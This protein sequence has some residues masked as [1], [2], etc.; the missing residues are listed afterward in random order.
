M[1]V[2][3]PTKRRDAGTSF[4]KLVAYISIR[5]ADKKLDETLSPDMPFSRPSRSDEVI[6]DR[7]VDYIKR[8]ALPD[9]EHII[10]TFPDGR[11]QVYFDNVACETNCFSIDTAAAEM[12]MVA[13]ENVRKKDPVYH[14][15]LSW[16]EEDKPEDSDIFSA[17]RH[18]LHQIGMG[19]HQFVTAIHRDTDN[20]H[21]HVAVNR[22]NPVSFRMADKY[23]AL[24][25]MQQCCRR[26]ERQ[27]GWT[28][29]NGSW[30]MDSNQQIVRVKRPYLSAPQGAK[31]LE[32]HS[33]QESL[34]SYA[35][36]H[37]RDAVDAVILGPKPSWEK[38]HTVL[39]RAGLELRPKGKG[40]AIYPQPLPGE[41]ET[42]QRPVKACRLHPKLTL[43]HLEPLVGAFVPAS[44]AERLQPGKLLYGHLIES[45]YDSGLHIRDRGA[46]ME[47]RIARANDRA[48]LKARYKTYKNSWV[49]PTELKEDARARFQALAADFRQ[50]RETV[51]LITDPL[52]RKMLR[53]ALAVDRMIATAALRLEL[54]AEREARR[55]APGYRPQT[56]RQWV[57]VQAVAGDKAA[58][59]QLRGWAYRAKR[60]DLT[61]FYKEAA[62]RCGVADDI[63]ALTIKG[64]ETTVSRD[65]AITYQRNGQPV[66]VD[67]GERI[68]VT[69]RGKNGVA[70]AFW[71]AGRKSGEVL[72]VRGSRDFVDKA[73]QF[74]PEYNQTVK[75]QLPLTHPA[76][77]AFVGY[78]QPK[79]KPAEPE[80]KARPKNGPTF[81]PS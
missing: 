46:R 48:D 79:P 39:V 61:P 6:F 33:D 30:V 58:V 25:T 27:Y 75:A 62:L 13:E 54:K 43:S 9:G 57:E 40:L 31:H 2:I 4:V 22:V 26:L 18:C 64:Y 47:R 20:V 50:R 1:N 44:K 76:Q 78:D 72:E 17:A 8:T 45:D 37:C 32:F 36:Q 52:L 73:L 60:S 35:V 12:N 10:E 21:C 5:D 80:R 3:V 65:G 81:R 66:M 53:H 77:R 16:R 42:V 29:D 63:G 38:L 11:Q 23:Q 56:Y 71:L 41:K 67:K 49:R 28:P 7:L 14:F 19:E 68:E 51:S 55:Q 70:A 59:S 24:D 34:Y 15:I 69:G 74:V